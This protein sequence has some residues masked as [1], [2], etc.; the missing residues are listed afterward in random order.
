[1][2]PALA[3]PSSVRPRL[4]AEVPGRSAIHLDEVLLAAERLARWRIG[5]TVTYRPLGDESPRRV[6][7][8]LLASLAPLAGLRSNAQLLVHVA[9]LGYDRALLAE[10]LQAARAASVAV[11]LDL[12][13]SERTDT[14]M[15]CATDLQTN[16]GDLGV[17][18]SC[19]RERSL[20]DA[21]SAC[22]MGLR[23]RLV[24]ERRNETG[25]N[26]KVSA[27]DFARMVDRVA[28]RAR[29]VTLV[30]HDPQIVV[31]SLERLRAAGTPVAL[32][33]LPELPHQGVLWVARTH[34]L[35]IRSCVSYGRPQAA[36]YLGPAAH[37]PRVLWWSTLSNSLGTLLPAAGHA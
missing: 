9:T 11:T 12:T 5:A 4:P 16:Y 10:V 17:T 29:H 32:E 34:H 6:A 27:S 8:R 7:Q 13:V 21:E 1:M 25:A 18:L 2:M 22:A 37:T 36:A 35:P 30:C 26:R 28:G 33:L 24:H 15:A 31:S 14:L 3:A 20:D 23:L 19:D